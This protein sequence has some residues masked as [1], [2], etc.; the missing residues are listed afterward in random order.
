MAILAEAP[1]IIPFLSDMELNLDGLI[2]VVR[3]A[4]RE[5]ACATPTIPRALTLF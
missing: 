4:D 1:A 3:S 2:E 5:R